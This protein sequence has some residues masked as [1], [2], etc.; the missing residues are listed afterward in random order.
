MNQPLTDS[1]PGLQTESIFIV[2]A[3]A[4]AWGAMVFGHDF[5][6]RTLAESWDINARQAFNARF[7]IIGSLMAGA[8]LTIWIARTAKSGSRIAGK[9]AYLA[10]TLLMA[11][12]AF[13]YLLVVN[14]EIMHFPQYA[15]VAFLLFLLLRNFPE[16]LFLTMLLGILDEAYQFFVLAPE[17]TSYLDFNDMWLNGIGGA[18]G[19]L[20]AGMVVPNRIRPKS[21]YLSRRSLV[22]TTTVVFVLVVALLFLTD[23]LGYQYAP[24]SDALFFVTRQ[25][26]TKFWTSAD[27]NVTYHIVQPMEGILGIIALWLLYLPME[28]LYV[29]DYPDKEAAA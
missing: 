26:S 2:I 12:I 21:S 11:S 5:I 1:S 29:G 25:T 7:T 27:F 17:K 16:A 22:T 6:G 10:L 24:D 28:R 13:K 3:L 19:L 4:V 14:S 20:F 23:I 18:F 15:L 9:A 8:F